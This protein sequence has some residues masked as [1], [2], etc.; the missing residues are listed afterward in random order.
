MSN[1]RWQI[2][3]RYCEGREMFLE[4]VLV[5]DQ[6][7]DELS[8]AANN[9]GPRWFLWLEGFPAEHPHAALRRRLAHHEGL[10]RPKSKPEP[11]D[12]QEEEAEGPMTVVIDPPA[13]PAEP[14]PLS[15]PG[16]MMP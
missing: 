2:W 9:F 4:H 5:R 3:G 8:A 13:G 7:H 10:G 15:Q 14:N 6:R 11:E 1:T 16:S 12:D